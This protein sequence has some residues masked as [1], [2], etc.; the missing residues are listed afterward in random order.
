M[1]F[2]RNKR[3]CWNGKGSK[4]GEMGKKAGTGNDRVNEPMLS[5]K[6]IGIVTS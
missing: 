6:Y 1:K 3:K 2:V 4:N 5:L